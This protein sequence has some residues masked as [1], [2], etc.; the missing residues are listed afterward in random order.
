[1]FVITDSDNV[2]EDLANLTCEITIKQKLIQE[3]EQTQKKMNSLRAHYEG[4]VQQ[5]ALKIKE[6]E[7]ERDKVLANIGLSCCACGAGVN[8]HYVYTIPYNTLLVVEKP[9]KIKLL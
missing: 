6:T 8:K 9:G 7:M 3:L 2:H 1:M 4:Q 5:L